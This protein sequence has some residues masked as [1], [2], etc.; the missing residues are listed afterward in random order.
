MISNRYQSFFPPFETGVLNCHILISAIRGTCH[1]RAL[2]KYRIK[3]ERTLRIRLLKYS[4]V[5]VSAQSNH[6]VAK[7]I[8]MYT[9][10]IP[11]GKFLSAFNP[12]TL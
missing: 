4:P 6:T 8:I 7:I 12:F 10:L 11:V 5:N 2:C 1:S 9:L 3:L